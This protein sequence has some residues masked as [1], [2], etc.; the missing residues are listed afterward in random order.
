MKNSRWKLSA[1]DRFWSHVDKSG[2]CWL[3]VGGCTSN[4]YGSF[5]VKRKFF[6]AHRW[7]YQHLHGPVPKGIEICHHCDV[8]TCVNPEHLFAG[9]KSDNMRDC[10]AKGR[11]AM[12]RRPWKSHFYRNS[13]PSKRGWELRRVRK[14]AER[15]Q[16]EL[17]EGKARELTQ[18]S[19]EEFDD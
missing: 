2:S 10:A 16:S 15:I 13:E 1:I 9:T 17:K 18:S 5:T 19:W 7:L 11:N 12:Q 6:P 14:V 3:W 8:K 4:G